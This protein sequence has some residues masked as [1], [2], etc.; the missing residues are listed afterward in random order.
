[1]KHPLKIYRLASLG[2]VVASGVLLLGAASAV[3]PSDG[4]FG[5]QAPVM[6]LV[7]VESGQTLLAQNADRRFIPA[8]ITKVMS[9]FVAFEMLDAGKISLTQEFV[10][11][12]LAA[13][14]WYR[15]G[16][17]MFLEPGETVTVDALLKGITSVSANDASIVLA[18]GAAGSVAGWTALMNATAQSLGMRNSH[19]ATPNGWPDDGRTFTTARDLEI[20]ARAMIARHPGRYAAYFGKPGFRHNGYSQANH[21]PI[22]GVIAGADGIKTGYTNQAGHG[23]LGSAKRDGTRLIMVLGGIDA[24]PDRARMARQIIEWGFTGFERRLLFSAGSN[25]ALAKVQD[26]E[27]DTVQLMAPGA[28][29]VVTPAGYGGPVNLKLI[30]NGPLKSPVQQGE[31]VAELE[32]MVSGLP[33]ARVPLIAQETVRKA[34]PMHR[35]N[36]AFQ[37]W[38]GR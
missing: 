37:S 38:I 22:S 19:F 3:E 10:F 4:D 26:G 36:N 20:L 12:D 34:G 28:I 23:F 17:T 24:E 2:A 16:S 21:D 8:S 32:I 31:G 5:G 35:I 29:N 9:A 33:P 11:S 1:M 14:K 6:L 13:E 15:T 7:D 25:V 30:Y 18:E 27:E